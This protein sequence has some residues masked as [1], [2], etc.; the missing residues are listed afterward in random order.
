MAEFC[1]CGSLKIRGNCTSRKCAEH[2]RALV[3]EATYSQIEY[4][5]NL[6][7]RLNE[8]M[9]IDFSVLSKS[10]ASK[11]IDKLSNLLETREHGDSV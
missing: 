9:H 8:D 4:I 5:K 2:K 11:L 3:D 6:V 10:E 7:E 1:K